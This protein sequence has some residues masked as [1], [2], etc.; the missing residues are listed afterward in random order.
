MGCTTKPVSFFTFF[1][2]GRG[3]LWYK[4]E[5]VASV[6]LFCTLNHLV[7]LKEQQEGFNPKRLP[8]GTRHFLVAASLEYSC[9]IL[10]QKNNFY[11]LPMLAL[12]MHWAGAPWPLRS[13]YWIFIFLCSRI[14]SSLVARGEKLIF[15]SL[16][17]PF[18][19][20]SLMQFHSY[21]Y[22]P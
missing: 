16:C 15:L 11:V 14:L 17:F 5:L 6:L 18:K 10:G 21:I 20:Y 22:V 13:L 8:I 2:K 7:W 12:S 1:Q 19:L 4:N 9:H 3:K